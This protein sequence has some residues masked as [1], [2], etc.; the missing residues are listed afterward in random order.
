MEYDYK[1]VYFD[2]Y[3][4]ICEHK[5]L[6]D[7]EK[8]CCICLS[9]PMNLYSHKPIKFKEKKQ[10]DFMDFMQFIQIIIFGVL[11]YVCVYSIVDRIC[12]CLE[13]RGLSKHL[14]EDSVDKIL[15]KG[16]YD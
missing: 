8:P 15:E 4:K 1:E 10:E 14:S 12:K 13:L 7:S 2:E 6:D 9:E 16:G 3:C 11:I 5:D